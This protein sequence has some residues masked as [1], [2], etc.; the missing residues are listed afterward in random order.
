MED[1]SIGSNIL[2]IFPVDNDRFNNSNGLGL[3][4]GKYCVKIISRYTINS[5]SVIN[6][7]RI[8]DGSFSGGDVR[9][10]KKLALKSYKLVNL[11][12]ERQIFFSK[13]V[14]CRFLVEYRQMFI[15]FGFW[16]FA[17]IF[18]DSS[19]IRLYIYAKFL[20][21]FI[22]FSN[23]L[24]TITSSIPRYDI[25]RISKSIYFGISILYIFIDIIDI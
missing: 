6:S 22:K 23:T 15:T 5:C 21:Y 16:M 2:T 19:N 17:I 24:F 8:T 25:N 1:S 3:G 7:F 18:S 20:Y 9:C 4:N 12:T 13:T 11:R 14:L 10:R